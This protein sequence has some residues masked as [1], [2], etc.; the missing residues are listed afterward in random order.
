MN[1]DCD[2]NIMCTFYIK[3]QNPPQKYF[4]FIKHMKINVFTDCCCTVYMFVHH[5]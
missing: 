1:N 5:I 2:E 4:I 3:L